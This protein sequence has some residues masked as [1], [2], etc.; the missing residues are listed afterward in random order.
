[1][2]RFGEY[3]LVESFF[4]GGDL[5]HQ[6]G[7]VVHYQ[8]QK[9]IGVL[10]DKEGDQR[11]TPRLMLGVSDNQYG[12][13]FHCLKFSPPR[14]NVPIVLWT[15]TSPTIIDEGDLAKVY[16]GIY[17]CSGSPGDFPLPPGGLLEEFLQTDFSNPE[18]LIGISVDDLMRIYFN[19]GSLDSMF[20]SR[21]VY[22]QCGQIVFA[23]V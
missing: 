22:G 1:M 11:W 3:D 12:A 2:D 5:Y 17:T 8:D 7:R 21:D 6:Q 15:T 9:V 23:R 13:L 19:L 18:S 10:H 14:L 4:A 16:T 20:S